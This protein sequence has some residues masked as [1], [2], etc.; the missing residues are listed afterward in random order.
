MRKRFTPIIDLVLLASTTLFGAPK[1]YRFNVRLKGNADSIIYLA[2]YYG[3]KQYLDDTA[4]LDKNGIYAFEGTEKLQSGMYV[5]AGEKKNKYFDF[6]VSE[7]QHIEFQ[8]D[9]ADISGSMRVK[10]SDENIIFFEYIAFL[11][12]KQKEVQPLQATIKK[13][14]TSNDSLSLARKRLETI[15]LE[16]K[17]YITKLINQHPGSLAIAFIRANTEPDLKSY[18]VD[19]EGKA[20]S[21]RLFQI[22][23]QHFFDNIDFAD[24]RLVYTPVLTEKID[25]YLDKLIMQHPD[26]IMAACDY[27]INKGIG[28]KEVF[29]F[30]VWHLT[31]RYESSEIMGFDAVFVYIVEK[32]YVTG[33]A[34]WLYPAVKDNIIKR[35]N[36]LKPLLIGKPAPDMIM[37]DTSNQPVALA[38]VKARYT[39]VFFWESNCGHCKTE[40]PKAIKLYKEIKEKYNLQVFA[41]SSDTSLTAWKKYIRS[42]QPGWIDVNGN[43]SFTKNFHDLYDV[44]STPIMFLLDEEKKILTKRILTEQIGDFIPNYEKRKATPVKGTGE[45]KQ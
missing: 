37:M 27:I 21:S 20:D 30:L 4:K 15:N 35:S 39:L 12:Q 42:H 33:I 24:D 9:P 34:D 7:E 36:T 32:Y 5:V 26:S 31:V 28:N 8:C 45:Q 3:N 18:L 38:G 10:N 16:V 19:S 11:A 43:L 13:K 14:T 41:V 25:F 40:M 17:T 6:F 44:H 2:H 1:G 23:R 29:K 22:Y